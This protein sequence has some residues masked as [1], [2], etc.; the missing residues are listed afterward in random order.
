MFRLKTL[1]G[2]FLVVVI[3]PSYADR[4][5]V[6]TERSSFAYA[7]GRTVSGPATDFAVSML[8][9]AGLNEYEIS[10]YPWARAYDIALQRP[11]VL[12]YLIARTPK[13]EDRFKWVGEYVSIE[14]IFYAMSTRPDISITS[15]EDAAGYRIGVTRDGMQH[16]YLAQRGFTRLVPSA[17]ESENL[18]KLLSGQ[19]DLIPMPESEARALCA[20]ANVDFSALRAVSPVPGLITRLYMA[21]SEQTDDAIVDKARESFKRLRDAQARARP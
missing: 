15:L 14:P 20:E 4:I 2:L 12:I 19:V 5:T 9:E 7:V 16:Q 8:K 3:T 6:V 10:L 11:N 1:L 18:R 21:F 13:R 17:Q